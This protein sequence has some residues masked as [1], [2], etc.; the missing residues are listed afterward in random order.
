M[1]LSWLRPVDFLV[2]LTRLASLIV[3]LGAVCRAQTAHAEQE[4]FE[5][6]I[7]PILA[8]RCYK[9]HVGAKREGELQ[10]DTREHL[11]AGG[12][13]GPAI[14]PG[15]SQESLLITAVRRQDEEL[16]MPPDE[17]LPKEE[18]DDLARWI[19]AGAE[20]GSEAP[21]A[22]MPMT[23]AQRKHWAF[24]PIS[25]RSPPSVEKNEWPRNDIDRF[26]LAKLES[27]GLK[28]A[29]AADKATVI[30][31]A[32]FD[33]TGLPPTPAEIEAF[34][35]DQAPDAFNRLVDR[36]L[37]SP[38]YGEHW[39]RHWLDL[40]RFA[41]TDGHEFDPDKPNA[42]RYRDYVIDAL[43]A[44]VPYD[45]FV[46]E[47]IAGDLLLEPQARVS[48]DGGTRLSPLGTAFFYLG[49]V[50][51]NPVDLE[52]DRA[53]QVENQLD[54]L[55]KS[56]LGLTLA[57]ARCHDHKFDPISTRDYY[58]LAGFLYSSERNQGSV[59]TPLRESE[60]E[61]RRAELAG[62]SQRIDRIGQQ[63]RAAAR[64]QACERM[65]DYLLAARELLFLPPDSRHEQTALLAERRSLD[66]ERLKAWTDYLS[67]E[68]IKHDPVFGVWAELSKY[69]NADRTPAGVVDQLNKAAQ[70]PWSSA[71]MTVG[72]GWERQGL[73]FADSEEF[74]KG[75]ALS[76]NRGTDRLVGRLRS[77]RFTIDKR[78]LLFNLAGGHNQRQLRLSL[79]VNDQPVKQ[80]TQ[81]GA[82][83]ETPRPYAF[84]LQIVQGKEC[85]L[86]IVD[87]DRQGHIAVSNIRFADEPAPTQRPCTALMK[88]IEQGAV[89]T[90]AALAQW[91]ERHIRQS[92]NGSD[93]ARS[94][95]DE[96]LFR[97]WALRDDVPLAA[98]EPALDRFVA[99]QS[100]SEL[101]QLQAHRERL[102]R[103]FPESTIAI[104]ARDV[105]PRDAYLYV[106]GECTN[107]GPLVP[108]GCLSQIGP[109]QPAIP[110]D[111]SGRLQ[112][113]EWIAAKENPLTARVIV[114]RVWQHHFGQGLVRTPDNFGLT[115]E[116]PSHPELLD[117]LANRFV[118]SGWSIKALHRL[119]LDSATYQ[120]ASEPASA[121]TADSDNRLWSHFTPRRLQA[122][123]VRDAILAVAGDLNDERGGP[124]VKLYLTPGMEGRDVPDA[125]GPLDGDRRRSIYLEARRNYLTPL[126]AAFDMPRPV[127]TTGLRSVS[128]MPSQALALLNNELVAEQSRVWARRILSNCPDARER[129]ERMYLEAFGRRPDSVEREL[130]LQFVDGQADVYRRL[131]ETS[132]D[133]RLR[134]WADLGHALF[135]SAEF[136][137]I[138]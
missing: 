78:Y 58:A 15:R 33:L 57:C 87:E 14:V 75:Q 48:Q 55:G 37:A 93:D 26:I 4:F 128:S 38:R 7:R 89:S 83:G 106:R 29:Q 41:E 10:V 50:Q 43:N 136:I 108:R 61:T 59:D 76:S 13:R 47:Q 27:A 104:V 66:P 67:S 32:T 134:A 23:D 51:T 72:P 115:G 117:Y 84:D 100:R 5:R 3:V 133:W 39:A 102:E 21:P 42:Y 121:A 105:S 97:S 98:D 113:A 88:A 137:V 109:E 85:Y 62:I 16:Q 107:R 131:N 53:N 1:N 25:D 129:V 122:E 9:C 20:W 77:P 35:A 95:T 54:V 74:G 44:D 31:R 99:E 52:C 17:P 90:P 64:L 28:P 34:A 91:Y 6:R 30:R 112:L 56:F 92:L 12:T 68:S 40:A 81:T 111:Y 45:Q 124:S 138:R 22:A 46:R 120:Q 96:A 114:N 135:N 71:P 8:S 73:A 19:D 18:I 82:G 119:I 116:A 69:E 132:R 80:F 110:S 24:Q 36:L 70:T 126:L 49:E 123:C 11:L 79:V 118:E 125:S 2:R 63:A 86:E 60:I 103:D 130:A 94:G 101:E 65:S 127:N